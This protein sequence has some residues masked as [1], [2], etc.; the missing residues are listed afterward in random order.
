[1]VISSIFNINSSEGFTHAH[2]KNAIILYNAPRG[3]P[4][5]SLGRRMILF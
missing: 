4:Y 3:S 2:F 5:C 1:M